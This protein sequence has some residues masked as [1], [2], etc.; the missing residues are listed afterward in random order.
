MGEYIG[1]WS[2]P[3]LQEAIRIAEGSLQAYPK[4]HIENLLTKQDLITLRSTLKRKQKEVAH[5][6]PA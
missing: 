5:S 4:H 1:N 3:Q 6:S 2:I